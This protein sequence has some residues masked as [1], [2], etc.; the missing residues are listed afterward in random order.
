MKG[1][2]ILITAFLVSA[3]APHPYDLYD[4]SQAKQFKAGETNK[5]E[6]LS[7]LGQPMALTTQAQAPGRELW[8]Y[9]LLNGS[10]PADLEKG[11][12]SR[13]LYLL[14]EGDT[15]VGIL[16]ADFYFEGKLPFMWR[17]MPVPQALEH[18]IE[19]WKWK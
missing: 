7:S 16:H 1:I 14:F 13:G 19:W 8:D 4:V 9:R 12:E 15:L 2:S 18:G 3:C 5:S 6:V 17:P 11:A 10:V